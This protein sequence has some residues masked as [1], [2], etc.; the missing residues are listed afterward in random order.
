MEPAQLEDARFEGWWH[1]VRAGVGAGAAI[2]EAP[3]AFGRVAPQPVCTA[4]RPTP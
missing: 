1:L 3:E 2:D 4:W